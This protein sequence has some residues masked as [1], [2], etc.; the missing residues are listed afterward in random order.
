MVY[1]FLPDPTDPDE[2]IFELLFLRFPPDGKEAPAP[3]APY[4]V[5]IH[6]SYMSAPGMEKGLGFVYDQDTDNLAAQQRGFKGSPKGA[7]IL[8]N[9][10]EVRLRHVHQVI[11]KYLAQP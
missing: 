8:G 11:D 4:D 6:E 1:R 5:D 7:E 9:Y 10:Q 3:A 2:C